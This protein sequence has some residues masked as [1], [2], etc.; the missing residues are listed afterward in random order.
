MDSENRIKHLLDEALVE[1]G[2]QL[3]RRILS[4]AWQAGQRGRQSHRRMLLG[5]VVI[6]VLGLAF[7]VSVKTNRKYPLSE[8]ENATVLRSESWT[9]GA[10]NVRYRR[11][12]MEGLDRFSML[13]REHS[14]PPLV[15]LSIQRVLD[16]LE[17]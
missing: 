8:P 14:E 7:C 4:D 9:L 17:D 6:L 2:L 1:G 5:V 11:E 10:V 3:D 13:G 15:P 12:G 16:K